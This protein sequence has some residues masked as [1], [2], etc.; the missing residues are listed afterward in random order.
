[1]LDPTTRAVDVVAQE[2]ATVMAHSW[3]SKRMLQLIRRKAEAKRSHAPAEVDG[4]CLVVHRLRQFEYAGRER[5]GSGSSA[6][7][8]A[9]I[10]ALL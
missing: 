4:A 2:F 5:E 7:V 6:C 9:S 10:I 8:S 1:M 3:S